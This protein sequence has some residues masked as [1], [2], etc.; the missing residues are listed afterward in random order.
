M[1]ALQ[2]STEWPV[3]KRYHRAQLS[4]NQYALAKLAPTGFFHASITTAGAFVVEFAMF[5]STNVIAVNV[6]RIGDA[7]RMAGFCQLK[8]SRHETV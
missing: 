2:R 5:N 6:P 8:V 1:S 4:L 3:L 7:A